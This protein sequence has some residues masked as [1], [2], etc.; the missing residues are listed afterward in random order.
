[1]KSSAFNGRI[2][3]LVANRFIARKGYDLILH[4]LKYLEDN[5]SDSYHFDILGDGELLHEFRNFKFENVKLHGWVEYDVYL[6]F[7]K[8]SDIFIHASEEEPYGIPPVD[9]FAAG[10]KLLISDRIRSFD[11]EE[12]KWENYGVHK[13]KATDKQD[14][15]RAFLSISNSDGFAMRNQ[16]FDKYFSKKAF[17]S[18]E[19]HF[20]K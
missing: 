11:I 20:T 4:L 16:I 13:F 19:S 7:L 17:Y 15:L 6:D 5:R 3:V 10:L 8:R 14:F 9:A 2:S 1:V 18:F 12:V